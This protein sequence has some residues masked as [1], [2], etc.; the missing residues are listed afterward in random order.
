METGTVLELPETESAG[1]DIHWHAWRR[2][3]ET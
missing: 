3:G 2:R 1:V